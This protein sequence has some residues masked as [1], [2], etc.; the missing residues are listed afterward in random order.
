MQVSAELVGT[1]SSL[2]LLTALAA[3]PDDGSV[4]KA[5]VTMATW[6]T[7]QSVVSEGDRLDGG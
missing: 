3:L 6:A 1:V 4:D 2:A 5:A 7:F